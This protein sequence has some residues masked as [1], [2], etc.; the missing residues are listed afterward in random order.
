MPP[1]TP[2]PNPVPSE[3]RERVVQILT[4]HFAND[5]LTDDDLD[6]RL[7]LVY[8]AKTPSELDAII[9]DLPALPGTPAAAVPARRDAEIRAL[10]SGQERKIAGPMPRDLKLRVAIGYVELDLREATFEPGVTT[11]DVRTM[12]GYAEI[13]LPAGVRVESEGRA[14]FGYF[15]TKG[16]PEDSARI[17]RITGRSLFGY[18][19]CYLPS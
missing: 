13:R 17:V 11:I 4:R 19:E 12:M 7:Q 6:A 18:T 2:S 1:L 10:F 3:A 16:T 9:S 5:D 14:L 8:A 15:A